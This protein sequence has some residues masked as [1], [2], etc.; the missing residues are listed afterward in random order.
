MDTTKPVISLETKCNKL[1]DIKKQ[2][3]A[4]QQLENELKAEMLSEMGDG[5]LHKDIHGIIKK[6]R[7]KSKRSCDHDLLK[8][9]LIK[10]KVPESKAINPAMN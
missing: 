5:K 2:Q 6:V 4:L 1:F 7:R 9:A 3:K 10:H 8:A